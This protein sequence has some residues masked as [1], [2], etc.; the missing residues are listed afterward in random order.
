MAL[1]GDSRGSPGVRNNRTGRE[2]VKWG[3]RMRK[4]GAPASERA[5]QR[6]MLGTFPRQ[7]RCQ[8]LQ[9]TSGLVPRGLPLAVDERSSEPWL[10][11]VEGWLSSF[12]FL[13]G[14]DSQFKQKLI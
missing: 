12:L 5:A 8:K 6:E 7:V 13:L 14:K 2:V 9:E 10:Q 4:E 1:P 11:R 3:F